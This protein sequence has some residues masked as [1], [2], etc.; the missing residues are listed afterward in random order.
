MNKKERSFKL[1]SLR[2]LGILIAFLIVLAILMVLSP[3]AFA[4][5]ANLINILK[6]ASINGILATGMMFVIISGGIDL[7]VGSIVALSGV[8]AA[9]FAHPG[10]FPLIYPIVLSVLAGLAAGFFNGVAVAFGNIPPFI[11]TLGS[12]TIIRGLALIYSKG[13]PIFG[14]TKIFSGFALTGKVK[15]ACWPSTIFL[16]RATVNESVKVKKPAGNF[17][18]NS[19]ILGWSFSRHLLNSLCAVLKE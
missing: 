3:K 8:I 16:V 6:Q 1:N 18:I 2:E 12:M 19:L 14:V 5:P 4:K 7:S 17:L 11:V 15:D 10:E 9:S 13:Q